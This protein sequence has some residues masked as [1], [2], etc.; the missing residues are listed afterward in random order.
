M[1]TDAKIIHDLRYE[2]SE[3]TTISD[4]ACQFLLRDI[5]WVSSHNTDVNQLR[6][7]LHSYYQAVIIAFDVKNN[8]DFQ[9]SRQS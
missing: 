8:V 1:L 3:I 4:Y 7:E 6:R 5:F 2:S 9:H